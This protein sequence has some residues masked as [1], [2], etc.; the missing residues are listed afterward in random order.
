MRAGFA[1]VAGQ[2]RD[3]AAPRIPE[4]LDFFDAL[5][6]AGDELEQH[7]LAQRPGA[8]DQLLGPEAGEH[9]IGEI[10]AGRDQIDALGVQSLELQPLGAVGL[11]EQ[12]AQLVDLVGAD[13]EVIEVPVRRFAAQV[14]GH[15]D[16]V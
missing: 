6:M 14:P 15:G 9:V 2:P 5:A 10:R 11:G 12:T 16:E 13:D 3:T 4:T 8:R 7:P 1:E